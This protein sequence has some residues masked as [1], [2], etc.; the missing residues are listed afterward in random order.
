MGGNRIHGKWARRRGQ[1]DRSRGRAPE[2]Q[3]LELRIH[4]IRNTPPHELLRTGPPL[5]LDDAVLTCGDDLAGFYRRSGTDTT[6][7][8]I[9]EAY[10][11]GL[12]ARFTGIRVA[13]KV[14]EAAI[15]TVWFLLMPFGLTN[16]AY[17][18]RPLPAVTQ[19]AV[20]GDMDYAGADGAVGRSSGAGRIRLFALLLTLYFVVAVAAVSMDLIAVQCFPPDKRSTPDSVCSALPVVLDGLSAWS[21][22]QRVALFALGPLLAI[23]LVAGVAHLGRTR[24]H[25]HPDS[26]GPRTGPLGGVPA[27]EVS[28][29]PALM[30]RNMWE[31]RAEVRYNGWL[32]VWASIGAVTALIC[33]D[34]VWTRVDHAACGSLSSFFSRCIPQAA[35]TTF[36]PSVYGLIAAWLLGTVAMTLAGIET[37]R[38]A[39]ANPDIPSRGRPQWLHFIG[40]VSLPAL[41]LA[42]LCSAAPCAE[43]FRC[44]QGVSGRFLGMGTAPAALMLG[45]LFLILAMCR[46]KRSNYNRR[47]LGWRGQGAAVFAVLAMG[48]AT[49]LGCGMLGVTSV[50]L[51][52]TLERRNTT[53]DGMWRYGPFA[54]DSLL[55]P[56]VLALFSG[57][58]LGVIVI[59]ACVWAVSTWVAGRK[60]DWNSPSSALQDLLA[61][62]K[63]SELPDFPQRDTAAAKLVAARRFASLAH[64]PEAFVGLLAWLLGAGMFVAL[65]LGILR[66]W[67]EKPFGALYSVIEGAGVLGIAATAA[68]L[69]TLAIASAKPSA[70]PLALLWDL[71]GFMPKAAHPFGPPSYTERTVPEVSRRIAAWL[72]GEVKD[73]PPA[74]T[75]RVVISAH[76]LGAI[77]AVASVFHLKS[78]R[79]DLDLSRIGL[80]TYGTQL[81]AYFGRFFPELLGPA[82]LSTPPV[83]RIGLRQAGGPDTERLI[84]AGP[85]GRQSLDLHDILG[86][87]T[88]RWVNLYRKT[89]YLGFPVRYRATSAAP[90]EAGQD[91]WALE[92][93][94]E[95][96][97]FTVTTHSDYLQVPQYREA[98]DAVVRGL[99]QT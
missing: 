3:V 59:A 34:G 95:S 16:A 31:A 55:L 46:L 21:R 20:S 30:I 68:L 65:V 69:T 79:P 28:V 10:S 11:W 92:T 37:V 72:D 64:R 23:L 47:A 67:L 77:M 56:S 78:M 83:S 32:H 45:M 98:I 76:S 80:M 12:L 52:G 48:T 50:I 85:T 15:R 57:I 44:N 18:S 19:K 58:L 96:Y 26:K 29:L 82:V 6:A 86:D 73:G 25:P 94:P 13:N 93:D 14:A 43:G 2:G 36:D 1:P 27:V 5:K 22:G 88:N 99:R 90:S 71:M 8:R 87:G 61:L 40:A 4:G 70:R 54:S 49:I 7:P 84:E 41:V 63:N 89:D 42:V 91:F 39:A 53:A 81:R 66:D 35:N 51:Q 33:W 74:G 97:Q 60:M 9:I 62:P 24:F 38:Q 17:W 75:G